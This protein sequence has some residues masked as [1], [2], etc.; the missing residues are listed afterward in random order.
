MRYFALVLL[1]LAACSRQPPPPPETAPALSPSTAGLVNEGLSLA[2]R[3]EY[4]EAILLF[5]EALKKNSDAADAAYN[6][7]IVYRKIGR[8]EKAGEALRLALKNST[9]RPEF[10]Y[11]LGM[12]YFDQGAWSRAARCFQRSWRLDENFPALYAL[13]ET[14]A[15]Q[16]R[17]REAE[18]L[19][20]RYL[21]MDP[22]SVWGRE[23]RRKLEESR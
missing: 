4:T 16:G 10:H 9:R 6:L 18:I 7:G 13:A 5:R 21:E 8:L 23:I 2:S 12:V 22:D 17:K 15:R 11:A 14:R 19:R 1:L 20:E 3:G